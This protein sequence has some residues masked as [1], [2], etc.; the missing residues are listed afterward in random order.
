MTFFENSSSS[1]WAKAMT[2]PIQPELNI[3]IF[4]ATLAN[5]EA[6]AQ[7]LTESFHP[8]AG[9]YSGL[10]PW[11]ARG[12]YQDLRHRLQHWPSPYTCLLAYAENPPTPAGSAP[13]LV[14][15]IELSGPTLRFQNQPYYYVSN[16]A[17]QSQYRRLGIGTQLIQACERQAQITQAAGLY[18][19]VLKPNET[20]R[21]F[22][23]KQGFVP[24]VA[25]ELQRMQA[26]FPSRRLTLLKT[27]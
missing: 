12:I 4:P 24:P 27:F 1:T 2:H 20:A 15:T 22:Y 8:R 7:L 23:Q 18:L 10:Q 26:F 19:H 9:W 17:V 16:L 25:S 13:F 6:V 11:L 21:R 3:Q 5:L 14:G